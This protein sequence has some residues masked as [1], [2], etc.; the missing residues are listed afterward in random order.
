MRSPG[1][2]RSGIP[3]ALAAPAPPPLCGLRRQTSASAV[4]SRS[5]AA[6]QCGPRPRPVCSRGRLRLALCGAHAGTRISLLSAGLIRTPGTPPPPLQRHRERQASIVGREAIAGATP[7]RAAEWCP[8]SASEASRIVE[9]PR[10]ALASES[11]RCKRP[12]EHAR[13]G[14][15][16]PCPAAR[17]RESTAGARLCRRRPQSGGAA[18]AQGI[19]FRDAPGRLSQRR[20]DRPAGQCPAAGASPSDVTAA[21][22]FSLNALRPSSKIV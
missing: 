5:R 2:P 3:C 11:A 4:D 17:G 14:R 21:G 15:R 6:D 1:A 7:G 20:S 10:L 12:R 9:T 16:T 19:P 13:R 8:W 18:S 22:R